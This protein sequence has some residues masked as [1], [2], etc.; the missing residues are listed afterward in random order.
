MSTV[1]IAGGHNGIGL[2]TARLF[3][4][5][6]YNL[7]VLARDFEGFEFKDNANVKCISFNLFNTLE[8]PELVASIGAVD[9]LI[10]NAGIMLSLPYNN[11]SSQSI[12]AV[13][14]VNLEAPIALINAVSQCM[15]AKKSGRIVNNASIAGQIGHPDIWCGVAGAGLINATKSYAKLLG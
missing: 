9:V 5:A 13:P 15:I 3:L 8:I 2:D 11:Y 12:N 1:L 14:K 4:S 6:N 7:V 10:N